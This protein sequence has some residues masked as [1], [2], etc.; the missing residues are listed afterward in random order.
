MTQCWKR[1]KS[2]KKAV[3]TNVIGDCHAADDK[4]PNR[5]LERAWPLAAA[6]RQQCRDSNV[7]SPWDVPDVASPCGPVRVSGFCLSSQILEVA[8]MLPAN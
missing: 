8:M 4:I 3:I 6:L 2:F 7:P 5:S 1:K